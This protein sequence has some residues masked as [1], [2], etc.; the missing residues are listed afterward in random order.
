[1]VRVAGYGAYTSITSLGPPSRVT[2]GQIL[3]ARL[4]QLTSKLGPSKAFS[5][6]VGASILHV[7]H[8]SLHL[9]EQPQKSCAKLQSMHGTLEALLV[10]FT[11]A[12]IEPSVTTPSV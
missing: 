5:P 3:W 4:L 10:G 8:W 7:K 2:L 12:A 6:N 11:A 1:M 9:A